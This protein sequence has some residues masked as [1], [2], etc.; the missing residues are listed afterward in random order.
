LLYSHYIFSKKGFILKKISLLKGAIMIRN[1]NFLFLFLLV[2]IFLFFSSQNT[3]C[4]EQSNYF[5]IELSIFQPFFPMTSL[6]IFYDGILIPVY[7]NYLRLNKIGYEFSIDFAIPAND[8][9]SEFEIRTSLALNYS[10]LFKELFDDTIIC[11]SFYPLYEFNL[12]Y[13]NNINLIYDPTNLG[14]VIAIGLSFYTK[15][16]NNFF[17]VMKFYYLIGE[18]QNLFVNEK[19]ITA[20]NMDFTLAIFI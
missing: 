4:Q 7:F 6:L 12:K 1:K 8:S 16:F 2:I 20:A 9:N 11:L 18:I 17:F 19:I 10:F 13:L 15:I 14:W 3:Y 5:F